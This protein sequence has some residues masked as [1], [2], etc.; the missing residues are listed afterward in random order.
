MTALPVPIGEPVPE[1]IVR[2]LTAEV[3]RAMD[4]GRKSGYLTAES[5]I[6]DYLRTEIEA[7][8]R[9]L[10]PVHTDVLSRILNERP[11]RLRP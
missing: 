11:W 4:L 2:R 7:A 10:C 6:L 9:N 1:P 5:N 8:N 3:Q